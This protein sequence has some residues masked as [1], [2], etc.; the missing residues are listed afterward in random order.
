M[1]IFEDSIQPM[2]EETR[3][4]WLIE[5]RDVAR[6]LGETNAVVTIDMVRNLCP[7]P[8]GFDPRV[9]GAVFTKK[10]WARLGYKVGNRRT[11][12]G[13]PIAMFQLH[14]YAGKGGK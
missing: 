10:E 7:P 4:A 9:M 12:H 8:E 2:F 5:A 13:R 1:G 11:S 14:N 6:K 3:A